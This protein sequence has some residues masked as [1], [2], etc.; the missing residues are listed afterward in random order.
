LRGP[1]GA[2]SGVAF[3]PGG[4]M[5][6]TASGDPS[7][8]VWD[9]GS[10]KALK[11]FAGPNGHTGIILAVALSPDGTQFATA[12]ADNTARVWDF[13]SSKPLR[14]LALKGNPRAVAA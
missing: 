9:L 8:K 1:R 10:G 4:K 3:P 11:T 14:E 7:V 13:P 2:V 5:L 6:L 12:G